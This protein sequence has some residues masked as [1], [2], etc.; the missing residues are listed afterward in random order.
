MK[1]EKYA[2]ECESFLPESMLTAYEQA[3]LDFYNAEPGS[4]DELD[5]M[6]RMEAIEQ[7]D[8]YKEI[9][10]IEADMGA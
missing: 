10:E 6:E 9:A 5:A 3:N 8:I 2:Y 1:S 7:E 4:L